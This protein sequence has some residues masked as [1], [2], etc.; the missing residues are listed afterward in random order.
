[1][2]G[3][4]SRGRGNYTHIFAS[5]FKRKINITFSLLTLV[6]RREQGSGNRATN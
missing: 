5:V 4:Q 6:E 1:M 3:T 2:Y